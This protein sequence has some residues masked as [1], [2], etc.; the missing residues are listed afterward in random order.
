MLVEDATSL[1]RGIQVQRIF[2]NIDKLTVRVWGVN[3]CV[4]NKILVHGIEDLTS[5]FNK[6]TFL[7]VVS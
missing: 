6:L 7:S 1:L 4:S 3:N 2:D 5:L